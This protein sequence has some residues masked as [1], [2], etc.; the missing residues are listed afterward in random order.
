MKSGTPRES[1]EGAMAF[2]T[3]LD[4]VERVRQRA[5]DSA[6]LALARAR[7]EVARAEGELERLRERARLEDR[8]AG[9][10]AQWEIRQAARDR[11]LAEIKR[12][13]EALRALKAREA[14]A[15]EAYEA[16]H[17]QFEAV[18]R[19]AEGK[20]AEMAREAGRKERKAMDEVA[21]ILHGRKGQ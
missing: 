13:E 8:Q 19:V 21:A 20:R 3:R 2:K 7:I 16:A 4:A 12:E 1:D 11:A 15:R 17:R 18:R 10:A 5:E 14:A 9:S 6:K